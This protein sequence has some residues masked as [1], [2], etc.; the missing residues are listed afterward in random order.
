MT[1]QALTSASCQPPEERWNPVRTVLRR[2]LS[3]GVLMQGRRDPCASGGRTFGAAEVFPRGNKPAGPRPVSLVTGVPPP[4]AGHCTARCPT[5]C[6]E[7]PVR[8]VR[9]QRA[10]RKRGG[11]VPSSPKFAVLRPF[12]AQRQKGPGRPPIPGLRC[13][14][15]RADKRESLHG[16]RGAWG[17]SRGRSGK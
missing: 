3:A 10:R 14:A 8:A 11:D 4:D 9:L 12:C 17:K 7:S 13:A 16:G 5:L 15:L 2:L 6:P 1:T